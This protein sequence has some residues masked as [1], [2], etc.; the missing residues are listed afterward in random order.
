MLKFTSPKVLLLGKD[1][2]LG[3]SI[4]SRLKLESNI[5]LF[6]TS[7]R[8]SAPYYFDARHSSLELILDEVKPDYI[9]NCIGFIHPRLNL[10]SALEALY[11]NT[12]FSKRLSRAS[13]DR[14]IF[15]IQIGTNAVFHGRSGHYLE[16]STRIPKTFYGLTKMLG[17]RPTQ[18]SLLIRCSIIG[19]E[20]V[21]APSK[22]LFNWFSNLPVESKIQGYSN[23]IWNG[24]TT[25]AFADLCKGIIK[26][27]YCMGGVHHFIPADSVSKNTLLNYFRELLNRNDIKICPDNKKKKTNL[28]LSTAN[29]KRNEYF[30]SLAGFD[31]V[32]NIKELVLTTLV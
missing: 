21:S 17:E 29:Q 7:R 31:Y 20:K 16:N 19:K 26:N 32:P 14:G 24:V 2:M 5:S 23:Q 22:S 12:V 1:G 10:K 28:T 9:I 6:A 4:F 3:N 30:W 18:K 11:I 25:Q 27:S 15:L 13:N 8:S